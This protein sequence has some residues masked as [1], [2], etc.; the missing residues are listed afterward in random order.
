MWPLGVVSFV[1]ARKR[2]IIGSHLGT[3]AVFHSAVWPC[4][5]FAKPRRDSAP[6]VQYER[7]DAIAVGWDPVT[8]L[9]GGGDRTA[10]SD[11]WGGRRLEIAAYPSVGAQGRNREVEALRAWRVDTG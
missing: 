3:T 4:T 1:V 6:A 8:T 11:S 10:D 5:G 7:C 9:H 2:L